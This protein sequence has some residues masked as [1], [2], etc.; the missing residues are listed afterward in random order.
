MLAGIATTSRADTSSVR[1]DSLSAQVFT[2]AT[3]A[4][5]MSDP[6][7]VAAKSYDTWWSAG[8]RRERSWRSG[9]LSAG[10]TFKTGISLGSYD[11]KSSSGA[12]AGK[13]QDRP[14]T[15]W[16]T[17]SSGTLSFDAKLA[18][19][20]VYY[21]VVYGI[22]GPQA[23]FTGKLNVSAR[24]VSGV[25]RAEGALKGEVRLGAGCGYQVFGFGATA[26]ADGYGSGQLGVKTCDATSSRCYKAYASGEV[27]L[28][29]DAKLGFW[30]V[31][32]WEKPL[33]RTP[34]KVLYVKRF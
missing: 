31:F 28:K 20:K 9:L 17:P 1:V 2:G 7:T 26:N 16:Y 32:A 11:P 24:Y 30:T 3:Y 14:F 4:G 29:V 6:G 12:R 8:S 21:P 5:F 27:G 33:Y 25:L 22:C 18:T 19:V 10:G 15:V 13:E 34:E 23:S